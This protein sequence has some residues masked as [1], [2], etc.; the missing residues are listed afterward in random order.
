[1][2]SPTLA[3]ET[4]PDPT[5]EPTPEASKDANFV[6]E[7]TV[8]KKYAD[9]IGGGNAQIIVEVR[10]DGLAPGK[11]GSDTSYTMYTNSGDVA[12]EGTFTAAP[13]Y[14]APGQTGYL[15]AWENFDKKKDLAAATKV[16]PSVTFDTVDEIPAGATLKVT[17][18]KA[19]A[20]DYGVWTET[21]GVVTN[22]TDETIEYVTVV[23]VFLDSA[24]KPIG[25]GDATV[26]SLR[27]GQSKGF[28]SSG[29]FMPGNKA[30]MVKGYSP[31]AYDA[32]DF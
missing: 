4:T 19:K 22:T 18:A 17:K 29:G 10:N 5:A 1:M 20:G 7:R 2:D 13:K 26:T 15:V 24:K 9:S 30:K 21:S 16:E 14:L 6:L 31:S 8:L 12:E 27:A 3:P 32:F 11:F 25:F 28:K 23:V